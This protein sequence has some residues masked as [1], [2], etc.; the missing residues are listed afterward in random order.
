MNQ[1]NPSSQSNNT[2]K[3]LLGAEKEVLGGITKKGDDKT[4]D[5]NSS[6]DNNS[7]ANHAHG[8]INTA[9]SET[10]ELVTKTNDL[11]LEEDVEASQ[12]GCTNGLLQEAQ[13]GQELD[14]RLH[15]DGNPSGKTM[16]TIF[17]SVLTDEG[18]SDGMH[19]QTTTSESDSLH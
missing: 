13:S 19:D 16:G 18:I 1:S 2:K 10:H 6:S 17:T 9:A 12:V 11:S 4:H 8:H 15:N 5:S 14:S 7:D 3:L